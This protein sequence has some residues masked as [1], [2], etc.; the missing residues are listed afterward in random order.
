MQTTGLCTPK[1]MY[2]LSKRRTNGCQSQISFEPA[3]DNAGEIHVEW[4]IPQQAKM[5]ALNISHL[6]TFNSMPAI[7]PALIL[8]KL[9]KLHQGS[10]WF[11]RWLISMVNMLLF[12]LPF[13]YNYCSSP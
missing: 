5:C 11:F 8:L 4:I 12:P 1:N 13:E 10:I 2:I 3:D 6:K 7:D 9:I